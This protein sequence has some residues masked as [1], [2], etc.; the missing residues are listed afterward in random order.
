MVG[1]VKRAPWALPESA[2]T[3]EEFYLSRRVLLAG[4]GG[5]IAGSALPG[6]VPAAL[7]FER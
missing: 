2:A 1:I 6:L 4:I 5:A 3:P 7:R